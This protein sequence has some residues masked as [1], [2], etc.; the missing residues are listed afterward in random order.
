MSGKKTIENQDR[1]NGRLFT[2]PQLVSL[3]VLVVIVLIGT[4]IL[5]TTYQDLTVEEKEMVEEIDYM[6]VTNLFPLSIV[7]AIA[8][9]FICMILVDP[10]NMFKIMLL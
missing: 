4:Y 3:G 6:P 1:T 2:K 9:V 7:I 10:F 5:H 8:M